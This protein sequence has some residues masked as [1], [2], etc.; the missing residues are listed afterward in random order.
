M[1]FHCPDELG[2]MLTLTAGD[3]ACEVQARINCASA[4]ASRSHTPL[5]KPHAPGLPQPASLPLAFGRRR[6]R[7]PGEHQNCTSSSRTHTSSSFIPRTPARCFTP[8]HTPA[9]LPPQRHHTNGVTSS[10]PS[11]NRQPAPPPAPAFT[12]SPP[13]PRPGT[14]MPPTPS[15]TL[16]LPVAQWLE[17]GDHCEQYRCASLCSQ[18]NRLP[19]D[20]APR[21]AS[22]CRSVFRLH[23][24]AASMSLA[25]NV[26]ASC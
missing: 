20:C 7:S 9:S 15:L 26:T 17:V 22:T 11:L 18:P 2:R 24:A 10:L 1:H 16:P 3:D 4:P 25:L 6:V 13:P 23:A 19:C 5:P 14:L 8:A 12:T 21:R